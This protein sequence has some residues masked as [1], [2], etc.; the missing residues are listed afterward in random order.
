MRG[1]FQLPIRAGSENC[2]P[3]PRW[4]R[5]AA[6]I[7]SKRTATNATKDKANHNQMFSK[8]K[9]MWSY[10][11]YPHRRELSNVRQPC[12]QSVRPASNT[13]LQLNRGSKLTLTRHDVLRKCAMIW[14]TH[15]SLYRPKNR[16]HSFP[17]TVRQ[18]IRSKLVECWQV[19]WTEFVSH[20]PLKFQLDHIFS[21][22]RSSIWLG[23]QWRATTK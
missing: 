11:T 10:T 8:K 18:P 23:M 3:V 2:S 4:C 15:R 19:A 1:I 9:D 5:S 16:T 22:S 20:V 14:Q 7:K 6:L 17:W 12:S 13:M 21:I